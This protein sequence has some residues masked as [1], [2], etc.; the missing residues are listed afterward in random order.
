M[1]L[2]RATGV[3]LQDLRRRTTLSIRFEELEDNAADD[4]EALLTDNK[5]LTS[6][7]LLSCGIGPATC[8][9]LAGVLPASSLTSLL[10]PS[11][12]LRDAGVDALVA[13]GMGALRVLW[14]DDCSFGDP[15]ALALAAVLS[16]HETIQELS[17][18]QNKISLVGLE[19]LGAGLAANKSLL[20]LNLSDNLVD[21]RGCVALATGV[22]AN[23]TLAHLSLAANQISNVGVVALAPAVKSLEWLELSMNQVGDEGAAALARSMGG[24]S[25]G[26]IDL[27][28]NDIGAEGAA[29]LA[30]AIPA[31][32]ALEELSITCDTAPG[33]R[34][35]LRAAHPV[36][37]HRAR[38]SPLA[39]TIAFYCRPKRL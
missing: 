23:G 3:P 38:A 4:L 13:T 25:L 39:G 29:A 11:N 30:E 10:L 27:Y 35:V 16:S 5:K 6:L 28:D 18:G 2:E 36:D 34:G 9:A 32:S 20:R 33:W 17:L 15:G 24:S 1:A 37:A 26:R 22:A 31:A 19:A 14:L 21:D 7:H 8:V 12:K